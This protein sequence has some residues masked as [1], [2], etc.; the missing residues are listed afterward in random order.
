MAAPDFVLI[1]A[2]NILWKKVRRNELGRQQALGAYEFVRDAYE[3]L[4][5][6][7]ELSGRALSLALELNHPAYDCLYLACAEQE[8]A[9]LL[10]A[11]R[12]LADIASR[13]GVR[14][15]WVSGDAL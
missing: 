13:A 12:R 1:E 14:S 2:A 9:D 11:D 10:T 15:S 5:P 3:V 6:M 4:V 7:S 8:G